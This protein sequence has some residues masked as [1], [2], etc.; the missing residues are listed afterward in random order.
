MLDGR[1]SKLEAMLFD[2]QAWPQIEAFDTISCSRL[3]LSPTE[4]ATGEGCG[5]DVFWG[6]VQEGIEMGLVFKCDTVE[7]IAEQLG[8]PVEQTLA[9]V[10][11]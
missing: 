5:E 6:W 3:V 11:R 9:S 7:E 10:E 8:L 2:S 4:P 1:K